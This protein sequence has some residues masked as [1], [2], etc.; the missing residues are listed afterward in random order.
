MILLVYT[1]LRDTSLRNNTGMASQRCRGPSKEENGGA[2]Y[3][4]LLEVSE[5]VLTC[6]SFSLHWITYITSLRWTSS[7]KSKPSIDQRIG[8]FAPC[9]DAGHESTRDGT[10]GGMPSCVRDPL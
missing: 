10:R 8:L 6:R 7:V 4:P 2:V 9:R 3:N 1:A 5:L